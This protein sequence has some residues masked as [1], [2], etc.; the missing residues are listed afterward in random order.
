MQLPNRKYLIAAGILL[1]VLL[2]AFYPYLHARYLSRIDPVESS[3]SNVNDV[4]TAPT[5]GAPD[6]LKIA[7]LGIEAPVVYVNEKTETVY[8]QALRNGVVHFPD[9]ALPGQPGNVYIFGHSSDYL[10]SAGEYK[11]IFAKLPGIELGTVI[12]ITDASGQL[13]SYSVIETKVV[14]PRDL[15]VLD[16]YNN[17]RS[18]LTL[19]TSYPLGTALQRYIVIAELLPS[20]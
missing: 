1:A 4:T 11:T 3:T 16:Q 14:G 20:M 5:T 10:W 6:T 2:L 15:S 19:Q 17:E 12:E 9:T 7:T 8:Q 18:L 13:F